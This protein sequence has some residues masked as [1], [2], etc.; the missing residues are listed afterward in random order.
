MMARRVPFRDGDDTD[1]QFVPFGGFVSF[2]LMRQ[3]IQE[4][5]P[6]VLG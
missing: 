6:S 5:Y 3:I 2:E 1:S 4:D